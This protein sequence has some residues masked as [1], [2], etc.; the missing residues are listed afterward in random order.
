MYEFT[1]NAVR[2]LNRRFV[3][4]FNT[5]KS[6]TTND[7]LNTIKKVK[8]VYDEAED[9]SERMFVQIANNTYEYITEYYFGQQKPVKRTKT[10][11]TWVRKQLN[12]FDPVTG[13]VFYHE[14]DRKAARTFEKIM[15]TTM[16]AQAVRKALKYWA[17][18]IKQYADNITDNA[19]LTVY[20]DY[21]VK[22]V[23]WVTEND[24]RVC[25]ICRGRSGKIYDIKKVP[26]KPH[27]GCR[28]MLEPIIETEKE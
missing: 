24:D 12:A 5:L 27:W 19:A 26:V 10:N 1:D 4:M 7:E 20:E 18:M 14:K 28:C 17:D 16:I 21:G 15:S 25:E 2:F 23:R 8:S 11:K 13:Y 22:K 3:R 9:I 6:I